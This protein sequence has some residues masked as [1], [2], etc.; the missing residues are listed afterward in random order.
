M[1]DTRPQPYEILCELD[2]ACREHAFELPKIEEVVTSW[3]GVAFKLNGKKYVAPLSEV[4]EIMDV[5]GLTRIP[6]AKKWVRGVANVRGTLLP[7]MDLQGLLYK[8]PNRSRKQRLLV[9]QNGDFLSSIV[10][11]DV[12][13]LQH[14]EDIDRLEDVPEVDEAV[15]PYVNDG[16]NR[17]DQVWTVF[18][19]FA[20]AEDSAFLQV[21]L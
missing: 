4:A 10:V 20:L 19:L 3:S 5:P 8:K 17:E 6:G 11:D 18:S 16:F 13:G 1:S 2:A 12:I 15:K 9:I 21:A 14:F 7:V